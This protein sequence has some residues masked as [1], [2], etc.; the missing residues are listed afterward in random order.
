M[1]PTNAIMREIQEVKKII[2][3][4]ENLKANNIPI[5]PIILI[6]FN[7]INDRY[8]QLLEELKEAY[9][10]ENKHAIKFIIK[11]VT[12]HANISVERFAQSIMAFQEL[13]QGIGNE[14]F[15][16]DKNELN[17]SFSNT[18]KGSFGILLNTEKT[19]MELISK[20]Y[21]TFS[22]MIETLSSLND[23]NKFTALMKTK[24]NNKKLLKKYKDFYQ[25]QAKY[26]NDI[27]I[28]WGDT[29]NINTKIFITK[30]RFVYIADSLLK[31]EYIPDE[32]I[33]E[34]IIIKGISL[35]KKRLELQN[36]EKTIYPI[37]DDDKILI[38]AGKKINEAVKFK[39]IVSKKVNTVSDDI[40]E[41]YIVTHLIK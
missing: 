29:V 36:N 31:Y 21:N 37:C 28:E 40:E 32:H 41:K 18:F 38:E 15:R 9:Q 34:T 22:D 6:S 8:I 39:I 35:I 7:Q 4:E 30:E 10:H 33:S 16:L 19:D 25:I 2:F 13:I 1:R 27:E 5:H 20:S 12:E 11:N 17:L 14:L 3:K 24:L 23:D 26:N